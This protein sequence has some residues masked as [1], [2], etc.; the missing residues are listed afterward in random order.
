MRPPVSEGASGYGINTGMIL[1][2]Y[3][4]LFNQ[5]MPTNP[6]AEASDAGWRL[7]LVSKAKDCIGRFMLGGILPSD[8][9]LSILSFKELWK[10]FLKILLSAA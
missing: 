7:D 3:L 8:G 5:T 10:V 2:A 6:T 9:N 1:F 4:F